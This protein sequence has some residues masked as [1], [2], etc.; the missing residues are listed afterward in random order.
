MSRWIEK[1]GMAEPRF[2]KKESRP[3]V[4]GVHNVR[5]VKKRLP[6]DLIVTGYKPFTFLVCPIS[7]MVL[8]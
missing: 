4:C 8:G 6:A 5:L 3:P 1:I 7:G 2:R